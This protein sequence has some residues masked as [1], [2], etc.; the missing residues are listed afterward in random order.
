MEQDSNSATIEA[1]SNDENIASPLSNALSMFPETSTEEEEDIEEEV[2][3][4]VEEAVVE[5]AVVED[6]IEEVVIKDDDD[7]E[8]GDIS[9]ENIEWEDDSDNDSDESEILC[10]TNGNINGANIGQQAPDFELNI[11]ESIGDVSL[12]SAH[13]SLKK[14]PPSFPYLN[15]F[16]AYFQ[17]FTPILFMTSSIG[18]SLWSLSNTC[19]HP[20]LSSSLSMKT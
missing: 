6:E 7:I 18:T 3:E 14:I 1:P 16:L 11:M 15:L 20:D 2:D 10:E 17:P 12:I 4:I 19:G 5:E 8:S 13:F 9:S